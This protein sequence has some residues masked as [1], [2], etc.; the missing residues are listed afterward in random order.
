MSG[1][2]LG[3][4]RGK[5]YAGPHQ[6]GGSR[7]TMSLPRA[8][9]YTRVSSDLQEDN[10]SL[11]T[12]EAACRAYC[13]E[14]GYQLAGV[15]SDVH[16]GAQYRERP[17]L[18]QLRELV[19]QKAID[20][21]VC[22]AVDRL[23][24]NQA[25][26]Y[27]LVEE[28]AEHGCRL[29]FVTEKFEDT[30]VGRFILAAKS[31]AAE[32]ER[33]K[34]IERTTRGTHARVRSGKPKPTGRPPYGYRWADEEKTRFEP[35]PD[36][37]PVVQRIFAMLADGATL[38]G[39]A[40]EL[41]AAGIP[42]PLKCRVWDPKTIQVIARNPAY[43]GQYY[44]LRTR[45][46]RVNG[47][48]R[49]QKLDP[50][51]W[52]LL[53]DVAPPLVSEEIWERVQ[54]RLA[55]NK[56]DASRN[57][58][59]APYA[60]LRG[61]FVKCGTCG[62]TMVVRTA[63]SGVPRYACNGEPDHRCPEPATTTVKRLDELVRDWVANTLTKREVLLAAAH[64]LD[65]DPALQQIEGEIEALTRRAEE[66]RRRRQNYLDAVGETTDAD[67]RRD[68]LGLAANLGR[69]IEQVEAELARVR[70]ARAGWERRRTAILAFADQAAELARRF[71]SL[72][73]PL[74]RDAL[75]A[76]GLSVRVYRSGRQGKRS[77]VEI[78]IFAPICVDD[79]PLAFQGNLHRI[80]E[81]DFE[82]IHQALLEA[83]ATVA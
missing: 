69:Q 5:R 15:F 67:I 50:S 2:A 4:A 3:P 81:A 38:R 29:E 10:Y 80:E 16:T 31:F 13:A 39:T 36:E 76:M 71:S 48:Q 61:G 20:V 66:L 72:P 77:R 40:N 26:L 47:R 52:V 44:G 68:L 6:K 27:I 23:S 25:H 41:Q 63:R 9:I 30:A 78:E 82:L 70:T 58:K 79:Y 65:D 73:L 45:T 51:E 32:I 8:A 14:H 33:E 22:Y 74:Q 37:A 1:E 57:L 7:V 11:P 43:K 12:Q 59:Y 28:F 19:R 42:T 21:V 53:P 54:Q 24:R 35:H 49:V 75:R 64:L 46:V 62:R 56:Q 55:N 17:G 18:S 60:L 83:H 34:I